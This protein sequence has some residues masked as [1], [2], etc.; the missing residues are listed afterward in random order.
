MLWKEKYYPQ[1]QEAAKLLRENEAVAFPTETV[2]GLGANAMDD[3]AIAKI[4]EA[5]GRPSDNPL[6]V[7]IGTKS[8]L[9]GI[10]KEIP[11]V[12]E[13]LMAHFGQDH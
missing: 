2:Y 12:A 11:P 1:L 5:K 3:E 8:Q 10:V 6:I 7:H 13:K 9:D 4:F